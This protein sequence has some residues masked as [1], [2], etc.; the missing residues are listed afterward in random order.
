MQVDDLQ[1]MQ[2][3][4]KAADRARLVSRPNPWVGA[5]VVAKTGEIFE[6]STSRPGLPHAEVMALSLAGESAR[7]ATLYTTLE[8][9][10][11]TGR[12][13][14]CTEAIIEAGIERV[15]I[16]ITDPDYKVSGGGIAR[17]REAGL[18]VDVGVRAEEIADQL[19]A[20]V[21]HRK[22]KRPFVVLKMAATLDGKTAAPDGTSMWIT[23]EDARRRVQQLRAQSDAVLVG[24]KTVRADDPRL[25]VRDVEGESPRRVVLGDVAPTAKINPCLQWRGP[26]TEL[27]DHLGG[28]DVLQLLVE[29]GPTVAAS[30]HREKLVNQYVFHLAPALSGGGDALPIF[31]GHGIDTMKDLWRGKLVSTTRIGDDIEIVL[32]PKTSSSEKN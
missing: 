20:Y 31:S 10:C 24:A 22:T 9:C 26:L 27:L 15:V 18:K 21:H 30:F 8:P 2:I 12:T 29:G 17:L 13:G 32:E 5:V 4:I 11:H 19:A 6:G 25:T 28:Q 3:A 23:G 1:A 14:P 7:N 16:G